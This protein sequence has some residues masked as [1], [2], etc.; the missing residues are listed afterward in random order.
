[1]GDKSELIAPASKASDGQRFWLHASSPSYSSATVARVL[2]SRRAP[3]RSS[4]SA[5]GSSD[6]AVRT[7]RGRWYLK[8]RPTSLTPAPS[9][10]EAN[11]SPLKPE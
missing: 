9:S 6:P 3:L 8:D 2:A 5:F 7:P 10:A 11:V 1:M 4:T